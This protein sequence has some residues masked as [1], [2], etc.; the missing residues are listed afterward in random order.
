MILNKLLFQTDIVISI[1]F[2]ILI[3]MSIISWSLI[4]AKSINFRKLQKKLDNLISIPEGQ[5]QNELL[6]D[7]F[8]PGYNH[9]QSHYNKNQFFLKK[10]LSFGMTMLATIGS[11]SPFIGLFGTVWGIYFALIEISN[12]GS[13]SI[14]VVAK[15]MGE[16][17]IATAFG[18]F[19]A[20]PAVISFNFFKKT[21][22]DI[23]HKYNLIFY[24]NK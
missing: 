6:N 2:W 10:H 22:T 20:I 4:F 14:D 11:S 16:A 8:P 3:I 17:L 13:A 5:N 24:G 7:I 21:A 23:N 18:L 19:A 12:E 1:V 15:P 9:I